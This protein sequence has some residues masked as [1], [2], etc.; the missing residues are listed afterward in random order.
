MTLMRIKYEGGPANGTAGG[1]SPNVTVALYGHKGA[2]QLYERTER[3]DEKDR[4]IFV[5]RV[6]YRCA[7]CGKL[8]RIVN[9]CGCDK[10]NLPTRVPV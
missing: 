7:S 10:N 4:V 1:T 2:E 6:T 9:E 8:G 3:R 5:H